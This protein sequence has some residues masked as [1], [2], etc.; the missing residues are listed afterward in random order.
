MAHADFVHLR[1]HSAYSLSEGA[2]RVKQLAELCRDRRMPAVAITDRTNLFGALEAS[3][4]LKK[5]GIQPIIG[6]S[7]ALEC[8]ETE[9]GG[10]GRSVPALEWLVF[11]AK[12]QAGYQNLLRL[13]SRAFLDTPAGHHP[14][15][16]WDL[17]TAHSDGL[18]VLTGGPDGPLAARLRDGKRDAARA[19]LERLVD[20][21]GDRVYVEVQRHGL[22]DEN[23]LEQALLQLAFDLDV[24]LVATNDCYFA[25]QEMY[26]AHDA[27][28]CIEEK[29][30]VAEQDR[31]R[32]TPEHRFKSAERMRELF[33]DL[34]EA[35]DNTLVIAQRCAV[36]ARAR[37]PILPHFPTKG[38]RSEAE[39]LQAEARRGLEER[40]AAG[41][42]K[43][44]MDEEQRKQVAAPYWEQLEF[45]LD[46]IIR[47]D[48]P[49]YFLIVAD[50]IRWAKAQDIPV[51][52]GR[53][54]GAG[55]LVAWALTI[56]DLDPLAFGLV[57]E[58]F[59]NPERV[60]MPDF[61]IDFCQDRRDEVIQYVQET[62]GDDR[63]AQ[64]ITFGTLQA[65]A[66]LRDV[67]RVLQMPYGQVDR[68]CKMVPS[69]PANPVSLTEAIKGEERLR[70]ERDQ[71]PQVAK[72]LEIAIKLEGLYRHASTH[73]AGVVIGDRPLEE[74]VPMYRDPRSPMPVTQFS[75]K[76]VEM[77]GLVKFD[78]LGLK[79]LTVLDRARR[80]LAERG[81]EI[82]FSTLPLDDQATY[83]MCSRG[84]TV[85]VFQFE[86]AGMRDLLR[87]AGASN[88]ED[89]IAL[90]AL[91]RP[92]PM[93]NIPKYI[94]CKHG[95]ERPEFLHETIEPVVKDTYGV[96][97]YQEQV[98]QIAQVFAGYTLG[99]ADLLRR[100]MGKKIKA[101]MDAQRDTFEQGAIA[102]GV[103]RERA[104][105]V[106]DL[107][108]KFAGYGFNKAHSACYAVI[109]YYT[110]WAKANHPVEFLAASMTLDL[111]NTDKLNVFRQE[112]QRLD[113][114]VLPPDINASG[115]EFTVQRPGE[116]E[117]APG[118]VRYAL[119][120]IKNVGREAMRTIIAEREANG[121][122][123]SIW[124]FAARID[125]TAVNRRQLENLVRAGAF[126]SLEPDRGR[127][128][129]AID[130]LLAH[131]NAASRDRQSQQASLF[132]GTDCTVVEEPKLPSGE[133]WQTTERLRAEFEAI[134]F[135]LSAHP[136]DSYDPEALARA[137][138]IR[139]AEITPRTTAGA[140]KL[141]GTV[142]GMK[143]RRSARGNPFAFV[144]LSDPTGMFEIT[145]FAEQLNASRE[146]LVVG[147]SLEISAEVQF[148]GEEVKLRAGGLRRLDDATAR[149]SKGVRVFIDDDRPLNELG[150]LLGRAKPGKARVVLN[151]HLAE[152]ARD[153]EIALPTTYAITPDLRGA[154]KAIG[155]VHEVRE[156]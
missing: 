53:G 104:R 89:L 8:T 42:F 92:G 28:L 95:R 74:L 52:P 105:Y 1:V 133:S 114:P 140:V 78:F 99:Q 127:L 109:A 139:F 143:E 63:V 11:L 3:L 33:H 32:L 145:V 117:T 81:V 79:T 58:R 44:D 69:N 70:A 47:M 56:T 150:R 2:I 59:L 16:S 38:G 27:L 128:F 5:A 72:L 130:L 96:I 67:G 84:E 153:I 100:A 48:F 90:V 39:E 14:C 17:L 71:D 64:I 124:D 12:D 147:E 98:M 122:F 26:E 123:A 88:I 43:P 54:S 13:S 154:V 6:C 45:E 15:I 50:F 102:K 29:T 65:R 119:A 49:G 142:L 61:D 9:N 82:D 7:L 115:V 101:E 22:A 41:V 106:F 132:G 18:I 23:R 40:L 4:T 83:E 36:M 66:A 31:R 80:L 46:V 76:Y 111:T 152:Q 21:F 34:P 135:Y 118:A 141:A 156:L 121:P 125:A 138:I 146:L 108:D 25:D 37:E 129:G 134:G 120:A 94:A 87:E 144:Q 73:A 60:S 55:S 103:K 10:N 68:I 93:E 126:D 86:S 136:L 91:Y 137:G 20:L 30:F 113:V 51:G 75:M 107:V 77:A 155:G 97:I 116:E 131:A 62:Y 24:P 19:V 35:V 149:T 148:E 85:G 57:F 110:A 151:M 112:A